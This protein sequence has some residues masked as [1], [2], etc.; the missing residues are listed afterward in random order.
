MGSQRIRRFSPI[1][2]IL[3]VLFGLGIAVCAVC[4][5][6]KTEESAEMLEQVKNLNQIL[7]GCRAFATDNAGVY[8]NGNYHHGLGKI[9][10]G[11][12][13]TSAERCFNDLFH[14]HLES[15]KI[16]WNAEQTV[17]CAREEPTENKRLTAG[18]NCWDYVVGLTNSSPAQFPLV[19]EASDDGAG[20]TW[21]RAGGASP[22]NP[23]AHRDGG[24]RC[25]GGPQTGE[26][27]AS[28]EAEE[29]DTGRPLCP[30]TRIE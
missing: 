30:D 22:G 14:H 27:P 7:R 2:M 16:F 21:S 28:G 12:Q 11:P 3:S 13:S 25:E 5:S 18:E 10:K 4:E 6:A 9:V 19:F 26:E 1:E 17:Q 24:R 29:R 20:R 23:R 8:P 15:E